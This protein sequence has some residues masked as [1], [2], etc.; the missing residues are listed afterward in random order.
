MNDQD[1]FGARLAGLLDEGA[2]ELRPGIAYRL[3]TARARALAQLAPESEAVAGPVGIYTLAGAGGPSLPQPRAGRPW[4][5]AR[6]LLLG[7]TLVAALLAWQQW[8][9]WYALQELEDIDAHILTSDLP[10]DAY[11][12]RGF[13]QW[14]LIASHPQ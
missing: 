13:Q 2:A 10:I 12:D 8:Q 5:R 11:L 14:L 7:A 4:S 9:S 6:W 3:Q 1:Q